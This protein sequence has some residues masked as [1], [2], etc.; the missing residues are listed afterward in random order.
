M[1]AI[2]TNVVVRIL[3]ADD[4]GQLEA[5]RR[6]L[7]SRPLFLS[8]SVLLETASVLRYSYQHNRQEIGD[9]LN[10]LIRYRQMEVEDLPAVMEA[11][12]WFSGGMDFADALHLASSRNVDRFVTFDRELATTAKSLGCA[13]EVELL[14]QTTR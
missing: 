12:A 4:P 3:T 14:R 5:A 2:D 9:A 1:I 13:P 10:N 6:A 7:R 8:K 11:L